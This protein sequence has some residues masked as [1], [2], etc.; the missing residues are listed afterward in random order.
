VVA[1][2]YGIVSSVEGYFHRWLVYW[3]GA[4]IVR[5]DP[6]RGRRFVERA[7]QHLL[8]ELKAKARRISA[9]VRRLARAVSESHPSPHFTRKFIGKTFYVNL[10]SYLSGGITFPRTLHEDI[11]HG[12]E[13]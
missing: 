1:P 2:E 11:F 12:D 3:D 7:P 9:A 13:R 6:E 10:T 4:R 8:E 5:V